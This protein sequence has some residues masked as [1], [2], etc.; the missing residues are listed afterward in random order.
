MML[1]MVKT[2]EGGVEVVKIGGAV[3]LDQNQGVFTGMSLYLV[4]VLVTTKQY[5]FRDI[6]RELSSLHVTTFFT[7]F[8]TKC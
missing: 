4:L 1:W 6:V 5:I 3:C 7:L 8:V 2:R